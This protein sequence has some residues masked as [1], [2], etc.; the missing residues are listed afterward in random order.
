MCVYAGAA[1]GSSLYP[2]KDENGL[3]GYIDKL[4]AWMI[5]PKYE[6]ANPFDA[7]GTAWVQEGFDFIRIDAKGAVIKRLSFD[8]SGFK[9]FEG[10]DLVIFQDLESEL[11]G[12]LDKEGEVVLAPLYLDI[13]PQGASR[14]AVFEDAHHRFGLVD[15]KGEVLIAPRF[16]SLEDFDG[17]AYLAETENGQEGVI[18][19]KGTW[20]IEPIFIS[21]IGF[22]E[23]KLSIAANIEGKFGFIDEMGNWKVE[24]KYT[25]L[26]EFNSQ[27]LALVTVEDGTMGIVDMTGA[28]VG[29][30][31]FSRILEFSPKGFAW[32]KDL[33][34]LWGLIDTKADWRILPGF[35]DV[36]PFSPE[37]LAWVKTHKWGV[38]DETGKWIVGPSFEFSSI[39]ASYGGVSIVS[40]REGFMGLV[41]YQ[42]EMVAPF[43]Y[44]G[45]SDFDENGFTLVLAFSGKMGYMDTS[46]QMV[47]PFD[48][49]YLSP[50]YSNG[51]TIAGINEKGLGLLN[52]KG[53]VI[54]EP[55]FANIEFFPYLDYG[56]WQE[57]FSCNAYWCYAFEDSFF[58]KFSDN[59]LAIA[60]GD[61]MKKGLID[62]K[63]NWLVEPSYDEIFFYSPKLMMAQ[64]NEDILYLTDRGQA[65]VPIGYD[66]S[67]EKED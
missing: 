56:G 3:Y 41:N 54:V 42:G 45:F 31:Y 11:W 55:Q 1:A 4:G 9:P 20:K 67:R 29:N 32:A 38:I 43:K 60:T 12:L 2:K 49:D 33:G 14:Q 63:G 40:D 39:R 51:L 17:S 7:D 53:E 28:L 6:A 5:E 19:E 8:I 10:S 13:L 16:L 61:N 48:Y 25:D 34:G 24:A 59:Y 26:E 18:D 62:L 35:T 21:I 58:G 15:H 46:G 27:G 36:S 47:I 52:K 23:N 57:D 64:I 37:G 22:R 50:F 66:M 65:R 44:S 30:G